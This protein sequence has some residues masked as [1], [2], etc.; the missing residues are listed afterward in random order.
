MARVIYAAPA[1]ADLDRLTDFLVQTDST[2]A[3]E[4]VGL[5]IEA[6][7]VLEN[8]PLIGRPAE[9]DLRELVISRGKSG[10]VALY[11]YELDQD[12]VLVLAIRHQREA[13]YVPD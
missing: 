3:L 2:A 9:Q 7:Q 10:Y 8:H 1:L 4:T 12:A 13:G 11:S 5:I 6:M